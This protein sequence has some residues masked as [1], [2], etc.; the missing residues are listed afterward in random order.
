MF[1]LSIEKKHY[2]K[3]KNKENPQKRA[4]LMALGELCMS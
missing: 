3:A 4:I 1:S 2:Y